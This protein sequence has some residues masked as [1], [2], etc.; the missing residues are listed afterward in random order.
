VNYPLEFLISVMAE[1]RGYTLEDIRGPSQV[2]GLPHARREAVIAAL[3]EG[4]SVPDIA[5]TVN[6]ARQTIYNMAGRS[7]AERRAL[8][9]ARGNAAGGGHGRQQ[10]QGPPSPE[11]E[12]GDDLL[13]R[14]RRARAKLERVGGRDTEIY[15]KVCA[16]IVDLECGEDSTA[17]DLGSTLGREIPTTIK[18]G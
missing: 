7:N 6:R 2:G 10:S 5:E 15:R 3:K 4:Y 17:F 1:K 9:R 8:A 18:W 11:Y 12:H 13:S 16:R 14:L